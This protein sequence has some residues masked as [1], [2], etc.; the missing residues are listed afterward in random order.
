MNIEKVIKRL[1][2][3]ESLKSIAE[4]LN[5]S[6]NTIYK[7]LNKN[8]N[9]RPPLLNENFF[10]NIDSENKAYW[11]GFIAADGCVGLWYKKYRLDIG[12]NSKDFNHLEKFHRDI[13]S[14][15][16]VKVYPYRCQSSHTSDKLCNDLINL[17]IV[18]KKSLVLKYPNIHN[19]MDR[20][21]IRG[22][23]DGDGCLY[24]YKNGKQWRISFLGTED[25]LKNIQKRLGT[26]V[27]IRKKNKIY[28]MYINGNKQVERILDYMYKDCKIKLDRKHKLYKEFKNAL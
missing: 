23:F 19:S 22:Y 24:N 17:G 9:K 5:V 11:L 28:T 27:S 16:S 4:D 10:E 15:I 13:E 1:R 2:D 12:L 3:G 8:G 25:I 14:S 20:H 7:H 6:R 21:F 18:P 26:N